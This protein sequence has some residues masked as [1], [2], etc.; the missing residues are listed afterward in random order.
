MMNN[1]ITLLRQCRMQLRKD[2]VWRQVDFDAFLH[3]D[4]QAPTPEERCHK[5]VLCNIPD[6]D[7]YRITLENGYYHDNASH[8]P[9]GVT[10]RHFQ[11]SDHARLAACLPGHLSRQFTTLRDEHQ[12]KRI[13][14]PYLD[15]NAEHYSDGLCIEVADGV[16]LDK[17]IQILSLIQGR[18]PQLLQARNLI[19]VGRHSQASFILC[20]DSLDQSASFSNNATGLLVQEGSSVELYKMQNLNDHSALLNQTFAAL[21]AHATLRS[22]A[23]TLNGGHIRNHTEV[24]ML[25]E[26]CDCQAH[27]LYLIDKEQKADNYIFVEHSHPH[28]QSHELFKG[29]LDDS[30]RAT[31]NGHVLVSDGAVKTEAYQTNRNILLTDKAHVETKPFLEI[32]NDDVKCSHGSTIGQ[33]DEQAL[34]YI[35]SRG[36]AERTA[37]TMLLY[38]FCDEVLRHIAL[39]ALRQRMADMVKKRLHGELNVCS[40]CALHCSTPCNGEEA[41]KTFKIDV[42]SL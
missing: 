10:V 15:I 4:M 6:L 16:S 22:M 31:F 41:V 23:I 7:T 8:L 35:R 25:G 18:Q 19:I 27:G 13:A 36:I 3:D 5:E 38:A 14:N 39:P 40:D 21:E 2:E 37:K 32:Y 30:A 34:F 20:D 42:S 17:P 1:T 29:I 12:G 9:A 28:C 11:A 33:L 24:R 26:G